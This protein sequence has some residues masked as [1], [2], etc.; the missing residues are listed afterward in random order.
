MFFSLF[1]S[2]NQ[3]LVKLWKKEHAQIVVHATK[4]IELYDNNDQK[5]IVKELKAIKKLTISHLMT[6]DIEFF[7]LLRDE[8]RLDDETKIFVNEFKDSFKDTKRVLMD[9][10]SKYAKSSAVFDEEFIDTFKAI[11]GV[12]AERIAFEE[13][14]LYDKLDA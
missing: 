9:F 8:D 4:I 7:R 2:K 1:S 6:E 13:E 14:N 10:L 3:K 5:A 11:V 12:L